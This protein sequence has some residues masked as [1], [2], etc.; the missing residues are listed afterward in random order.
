VVK[1]VEID[2]HRWIIAPLPIKGLVVPQFEAE[3]KYDAAR[4]FVQ[5]EPLA[6][7]VVAWDR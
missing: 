6:F 3:L 4:A 2:L 7:P 5:E 1:T